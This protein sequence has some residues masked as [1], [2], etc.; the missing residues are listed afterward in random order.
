MKN[1]YFKPREPAEPVDYEEAYWGTIVDPDGKVRN[2]L[3]EREKYLEDVKQEL[4]FLK[5]LPPGR[6]LD[7]GCGLGFL[8]SGLEP[9]WEKH[10]LVGHIERPKECYILPR[11]PV[12]IVSSHPPL[13][14]LL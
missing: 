8:L 14:K 7:V 6:I 5:Q 12:D 13:Q 1:D 10:G 2:R 3:E 4:T 9:A 11:R